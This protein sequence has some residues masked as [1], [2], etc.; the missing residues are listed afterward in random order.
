MGARRPTRGSRATPGSSAT[1][2]PA[3]HNGW[4]DMRFFKRMTVAQAAGVGGGSLT[5][6][7][8]AVEAN[9]DVF[10]TGWPAEI[11]YAELKPYY[12]TVA[13]EM[14]LQV[15]PDGQLTP[16]FEIAREAAHNLGYDDRF[17]KAGSGRQLLRGLELPISRIAFNPKH[18]QPVHERS[19][20]ATGHLHPSRQLRHRLRRARQERAGRQL[21]S[22]SRAARRRGAAAARGAI[23]RAEGREVPRR[24]RSHRARAN[25]SRRGN[26]RSAS[27]WPREAWAPRSSCSGAAT[28]TGRC[29]RSAASLGTHWSGN[30]NFISMGSYGRRRAASGSRPA[31]TISS[32]LDFTDGSFKNQRFVVED[33]GFPNVLLNALKACLDNRVGPRSARHLLEDF[34]EHLRDDTP[35]PQPDGLA[36]RR[37]GRGRRSVPSEAARG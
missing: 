19:R 31:S 14:D 26:R 37:H 33:D 18:S 15:I 3:R 8:V 7:S 4:L 30:A 2:E 27:S 25:D 20:S 22:A 35:A 21:H 34:E 6:S 11:T 9:P 10:T 32:M 28:S 12:D 5:Y 17:S 16:R 13:R 29:R 24:L 36:G 1:T 23:H